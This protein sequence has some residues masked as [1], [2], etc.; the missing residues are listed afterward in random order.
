[1][2]APAVS[3]PPRR[4]NAVTAQRADEGVVGGVLRSRVLW[5]GD[6]EAGLKPLTPEGARYRRSSRRVGLA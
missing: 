5:V 4:A 6:A 3:T 2:L 1:M